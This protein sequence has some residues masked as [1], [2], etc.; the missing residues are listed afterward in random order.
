MGTSVHDLSA[1]YSIFSNEFEKNKLCFIPNAIYITGLIFLR[2]NVHSILNRQR[3]FLYKSH[4]N[5]N[6]KLVT[7]N[8]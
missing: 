8:L 2:R 7:Q 3:N 5:G 4:K 6:K 1:P